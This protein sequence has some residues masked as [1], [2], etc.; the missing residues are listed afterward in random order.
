MCYGVGTK[1][2]CVTGGR[3][4]VWTIVDAERRVVRTRERRPVYGRCIDVRFVVLRA[5]HGRADGVDMTGNA[6]CYIRVRTCLHPHKDTAV[7]DMPELVAPKR[8]GAG[9]ARIC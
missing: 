1:S 2:G 6:S 4:R 5:Y 8:M 3:R 7:V 9:V